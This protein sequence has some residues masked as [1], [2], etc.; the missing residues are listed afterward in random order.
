MLTV[1]VNA[2]YR[3]ETGQYVYRMEDGKRVRCEVEVGMTSDVKAEILEG[4]QEG[5]EVYV[6]E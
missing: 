1:P 2:L 4:L 5:D 3:D 6:K